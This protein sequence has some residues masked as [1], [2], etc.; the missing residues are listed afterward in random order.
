M[1]IAHYINTAL[2]SICLILIVIGLINKNYGFNIIISHIILGVSQPILSLITLYNA[3]SND[4]FRYI[5]YYWM[6]VVVFF[7]LILIFSVLRLENTLLAT[8]LSIS[9]TLIATYFVFTTYKIQK[10]N[11]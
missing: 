7:L 10:D 6:F 9:P 5:S 4:E 1:K 3:N 8:I 2:Y 11:S